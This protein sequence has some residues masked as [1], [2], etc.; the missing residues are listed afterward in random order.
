MAVDIPKNI[1]Y[2]EGGGSLPQ[3][4]RILREIDAKLDDLEERVTE[5]ENAE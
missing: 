5:L 2:G 1:G 4:A 3:L